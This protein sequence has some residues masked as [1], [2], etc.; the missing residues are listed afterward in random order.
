MLQPNNPDIDFARLEQAIQHAATH[1]RHATR[2]AENR[3]IPFNAVGIPY[4]NW[5][6]RVRAW[7]VAG[8]LLAH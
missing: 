4:L 6:Q 3:P 2:L 7:P 8:P 5:R 1:R